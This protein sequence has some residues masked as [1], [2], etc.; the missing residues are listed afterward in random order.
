V[1]GGRF[2]L[3]IVFHKWPGLRGRH[4]P[5]LLHDPQIP[6]LSVSGKIA[7]QN[8][9]RGKFFARQTWQTRRALYVIGSG[10]GVNQEKVNQEK[11]PPKEG[12][13]E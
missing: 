1:S 8:Q 3:S 13:K 5:G 10:K 6:R 2:D 9:Y 12:A 11:A 4:R 7:P